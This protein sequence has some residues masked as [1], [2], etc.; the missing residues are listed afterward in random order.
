[1]KGAE[2]IITEKSMQP[3]KTY[4]DRLQKL[5]SQL[6]EIY[7]KV[8]QE[9]QQQCPE[10]QQVFL[11]IDED[12]KIRTMVKNF[13]ESYGF[14]TVTAGNGLEALNHFNNASYDLI[15]VLPD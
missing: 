1:M 3:A 5:Q 12:E 13:F 9:K 11:I 8:V 15:L 14:N 4:Q 7:Q 10:R 6:A 2:C